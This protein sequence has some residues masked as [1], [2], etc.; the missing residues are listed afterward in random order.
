MDL[1]TRTA[2]ADECE[3]LRAELARIDRVLMEGDAHDH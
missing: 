2:N 1:L 3:Q